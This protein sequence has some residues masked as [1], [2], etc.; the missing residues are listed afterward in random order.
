MMIAK[1]SAEW[2]PIL[3]EIE[4]PKKRIFTQGGKTRSEFNRARDQLTEWRAWFNDH[5]NVDQFNERYGISDYTKRP[6]RMQIE[7]VLV[8]GRR[9]EFDGDHSLTK[10]RASLMNRSD[11]LMSFDRLTDLKLNDLDCQIAITIKSTGSGHFKAVWIPETFTL[12]PEF[13]NS[14]HYISGID[15]AIC[16]NPN[17]SDARKNFLVERI[18]YWKAWAR[19]GSGGIRWK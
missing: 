12:G 14:L 3:I 8:Y 19:S 6:L 17:I 4:S 7:T 16:S 5:S 13:A 1:N 11:R 2:R 10:F 9:S 15:S 18:D